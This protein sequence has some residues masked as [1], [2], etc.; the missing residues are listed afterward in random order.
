MPASVE[1]VLQPDQQTYESRLTGDVVPAVA[2]VTT[3][4]YVQVTL[5][6]P[7]VLQPDGLSY[8]NRLTGEVFPAWVPPG[9]LLPAPTPVVS[10]VG[11]AP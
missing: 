1:W 2:P 11:D 4:I 5:S 10:Y 6:E 7:W 8:E 9:T 3:T